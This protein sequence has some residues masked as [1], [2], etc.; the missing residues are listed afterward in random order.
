MAYCE[1]PSSESRY[2]HEGQGKVTWIH[3]P[4]A[5]EFL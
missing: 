5:R 3:L 2:S 4:Y 1:E